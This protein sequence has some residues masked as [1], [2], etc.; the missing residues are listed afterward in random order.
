MTIPTPP[1]D[2]SGS[3]V[4]ASGVGRRRYFNRERE[5]S[6]AAFA[7]THP[8]ATYEELVGFAHEQFGRRVDRQTI[9]TTLKRQGVA[10]A[11]RGKRPAPTEAPSREKDLKRYGY[12]PHHRR[13]APQGTYPSSLTDAEWSLVQDVFEHTGG[14]RRPEVDR[15]IM[16]DAVLYVVRGGT[17]WR[18]LPADF[19][20]WT[21][22]YASFRRWV[23]DGVMEKMYDRL[24]QMWLSR[25]EREVEPTTSV[26]DSQSVKTSPQ[27]GPRGYDGAKRLVGRKR[28]LLVDTLGLLL[29]VLITPAN[30]QDREAA[31][32]LLQFGKSK[33]PSLQK[34]YVDCGYLG[35][36]TSAAAPAVG[37]QLQVVK[38]PSQPKRGWAGAG[39]LPLW[40]RATRRWRRCR[41]RSCPSAGSSSATTRGANGLGA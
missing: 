28:H 3:Q 10:K 16:L 6:I 21:N 5:A 23:R 1:T 26:L 7:V 36:R 41:F 17:S 13:P 35:A 40:R 8:A 20:N 11:R 29:A 38:R 2:A 39:K 4:K 31:A 19:P 15:R 27:G 37:V 25:H 24:R 22:V 18:M 30:V 9:A 32:P 33:Y 12:L 14:G 34:S